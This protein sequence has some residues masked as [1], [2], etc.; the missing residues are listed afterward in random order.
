[1]PILL[2][3]PYDPGD[4]DPGNSYTHVQPLPLKIDDET[5]RAE[6]FM[7]YGTF[8]GS[9]FTAA[10]GPAGNKVGKQ[11][12]A[13]NVIGSTTDY[14]DYEAILSQDGEKGCAAAMRA[15]CQYCVDKLEF[16]GS[17]V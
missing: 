17:V 6:A 11:V 10:T 4:Y 2:N 3:T 7:A 13:K 9:V 12:I 5:K 14:D 1:M 8:D 15:F 16:A